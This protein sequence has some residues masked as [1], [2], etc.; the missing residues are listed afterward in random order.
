[1]L[2]PSKQ[3]LA[4]FK[5]RPWKEVYISKDYL[6]SLDYFYDFTRDLISFYDHYNITPVIETDASS[7]EK[8]EVI[9][10]LLKIQ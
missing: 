9:S 3:F 7:K 4:R 1:V 10:S 8:L 5:F 6:S 2:I